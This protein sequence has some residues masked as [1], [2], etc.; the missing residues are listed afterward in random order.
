MRMYK[1]LFEADR[2][3]SL[4]K[5][6]EEADILYHVTTK[7]HWNSIKRNGLKMAV[8]QDMEGEE[9]GVYL[10]RNM[11]DV[12]DA[13]MNWLGDRFDEDEEL[14]VIKVNGIYVDTVSSDAADYEVIAKNDIPKQAIL[15]YETI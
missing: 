13:L 9:I 12:E 1:L 14:I 15:G 11:N 6:L 8:P 7:K 2:K 5:S 3:T 4:N 10:F